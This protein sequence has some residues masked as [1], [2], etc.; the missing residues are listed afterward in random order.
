MDYN[1]TVSIYSQIALTFA[2]ITIV[3]ILVILYFSI[4]YATVT[5][6]PRVNNMS[7]E[8]MHTVDAGKGALARGHIPGRIVKTEV[9]GER[10]F[11]SSFSGSGAPG[12]AEGI[13]SITN[14]SDVALPLIPKTR[15]LSEEGVL[16]RLKNHTSVP[17]G[18]TI[19]APA[20]ADVAGESGNIGPSSFTVPGLG[21]NF[22]GIV[23]GESND[24]MT[25]GILYTYE[26]TQTDVDSAAEFLQDQLEQKALLSLNSQQKIGEKLLEEATNVIVLN[27]GVSEEI[28]AESPKFKIE[29][30]LQVEVLFSDEQKIYDL[31]K[32]ELFQKASG[33]MEIIDVDKKSLKYTIEK[34]DEVDK[35]AQVWVELRGN[36]VLKRTSSVLEKDNFKGLTERDIV[37]KLRGKYGIE[38]V[39]VTF[40]PFWVKSVPRL[41]DHINIV[42]QYNDQ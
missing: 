26:V 29:M 24:Y 25:G 42:I 6:V 7:V 28:G 15:F 19:D 39:D 31:A 1:R 40:S 18:K 30:T 37:D 10:V 9:T 4:S 20:Y 13:I 3:V 11:D 21:D 27:D 36:G 34:Y 5:I 16:F 35:T 32:D 8:F 41:E 33:E 38:D 17:A 2:G 22:L 14:N 12:V 23:F